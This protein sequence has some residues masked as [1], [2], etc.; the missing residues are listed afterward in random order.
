MPN[1][2][3]RVTT[4]T[5]ESELV[6]L[7]KEYTELM[8]EFCKCGDQRKAKRLHNAIEALKIMIDYYKELK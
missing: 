7:Q 8:E 3:K 2:R 5:S 1:A 6:R 4:P